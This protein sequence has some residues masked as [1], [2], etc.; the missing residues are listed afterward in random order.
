MQWDL[1]HSAGA[2]PVDLTAAGADLAVGCTYKYLNGGP[3]S[4]AFV[5]V[6]P[7]HQAVGAAADH[8][9]DRARGRRSRW[10]ATTSRPTG[11]GAFASGT[12]PVLAL[13]ALEAALEAFD[14]VSVADAAARARS[15]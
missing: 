9:L 10:R 1:C 6:A 12:P 13:S 5:W 14:G 15:S 7:Q 3:G 2:V 4:P 11:I 8:R